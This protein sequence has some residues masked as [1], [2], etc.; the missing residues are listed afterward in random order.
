MTT[1]NDKL[2]KD[3]TKRKKL[4]LTQLNKR[5]DKLLKDTTKLLKQY[6][7]SFSSKIYNEENDDHDIIMDVFN[8]TPELKRENRQY[9]GRELGMFWQRLV[10]AT[11]Q[12]ACPDKFSPAPKYGKDEPVDLIVGQ[13]AIDT[14]YRVGSGD[15]GTLKKFK[16]YGAMMKKMGYTPVFLMVRND[17]LPAAMTAIKQ[18]GWVAYT[19]DDALLFIESL[20][21]IDLKLILKLFND[22]Y[23]I[24]RD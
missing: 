1:F 16:Q 15:S 14:K 6:S 9:W 10:I 24:K 19:G 7:D 21:G 23:F 22:N 17:N 3:T 12:H 20:S 18:G 11:F 8:I 5:N 4:T 13:Y 2:L